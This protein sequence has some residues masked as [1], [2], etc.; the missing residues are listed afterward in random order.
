RPTV[1]SCS[2]NRAA[3]RRSR[4]RKAAMQIL[5]LNSRAATSISPVS[6]IF[7]LPESRQ[8]VRQTS[9][10]AAHQIDPPDLLPRRVCLCLELVRASYPDRKSTRLNSSHVK[11]SYAVFCLK[12]KKR[13]Y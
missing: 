5:Q 7:L 11:I 4:S 3:E 9:S 6:A 12:K 13:Y 8:L 1:M 10:L 2:R